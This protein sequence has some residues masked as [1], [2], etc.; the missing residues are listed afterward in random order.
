M[1]VEENTT[2]LIFTGYPYASDPEQITI[3][4]LYK[5]TAKMVFNKHYIINKVEK[6][7][8]SL[9]LTLHDQVIEYDDDGNINTTGIFKLWNENGELKFG[10]SYGTASSN[11]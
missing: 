1:H 5:D 8:N 6:V 7:A 9:I 10:G 4:V 11:Y 2:A 3:V